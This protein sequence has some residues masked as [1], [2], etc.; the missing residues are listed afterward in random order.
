MEAAVTTTGMELGQMKKFLIFVIVLTAAQMAAAQ[1]LEEG[2]GPYCSV[3]AEGT[4][5]VR[6]VSIYLLDDPERL[7]IYA[8]AARVLHNEEVSV[9]ADWFPVAFRVYGKPEG[10]SGFRNKGGCGEIPP[11]KVDVEPTSTGVLYECE[12]DLKKAMSYY[13]YAYYLHPDPVKPTRRFRFKSE[14][15]TTDEP[16]TLT[17]GYG[18]PQTVQWWYRKSGTLAHYPEGDWVLAKECELPEG[19]SY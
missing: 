3:E 13:V 19:G 9:V 2:I 1:I 17:M 15:V 7:Y 11:R 6:L 16:I 14:I 8:D 18:Y 4:V 10:A 12:V 5:E